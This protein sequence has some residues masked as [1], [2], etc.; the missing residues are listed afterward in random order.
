MIMRSTGL[1]KAE[2]VVE[3]A[4]IKPMGDYLIMEMQTTEPVRWK[5]RVG[6]S[7]QDMKSLFKYLVRM[8]LIKFMLNLKGWFKT[9]QHPGDY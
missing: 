2:L 4:D 6:L 9:P 1:G 5:V 8:S 7:R 3:L